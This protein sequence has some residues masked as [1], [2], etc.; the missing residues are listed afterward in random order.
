MTSAILTLL[1]ITLFAI[2][3]LT[4]SAPD[5]NL[6]PGDEISVADEETQEAAIDSL[7]DPWGWLEADPVTGAI[8]VGDAGTTQSVEGNHR[9]LRVRR[10][11][12]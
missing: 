11:S 7:P 2:F 1:V 6:E 5:K 12:A 10:G 9:T 4:A 8:T 3:V